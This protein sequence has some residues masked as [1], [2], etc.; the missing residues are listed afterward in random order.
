MS[1]RDPLVFSV[2]RLSEGQNIFEFEADTEALELA[3]YHFTRPLECRVT[4]TRTGRRV[5]LLLRIRTRVR[6]VCAGC[7]EPIHRDVENL[8]RVTF[9]PGSESAEGTEGDLEFYDE[10]IDLR[11]VTHDAF[12]LAL[13][14]AP[15]CR[16]DCRGLCPECGA[17]LN[18]ETCGCEGRTKP[19][20]FEELRRLVDG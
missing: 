11:G 20:P 9:L 16:E 4:L 18:R 6:L 1:T 5:D 12:V 15:L 19:S 13:P 3:S 17:N 10:D 7:G 2:H 14:I 8:V